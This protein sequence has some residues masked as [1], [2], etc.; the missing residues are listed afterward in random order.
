MSQENPSVTNN[1]HDS[2]P[3]DTDDDTFDIPV[4]QETIESDPTEDNNESPNASEPDSIVTLSLGEALLDNNADSDLAAFEAMV[5]GRKPTLPEIN[6]TQVEATPANPAPIPP[7]YKTA[8]PAYAPPAQ[9]VVAKGENPFLPK[10]ILDRLNHGKRNLV[11]EIAQSGAALDASTA[12]LR[13]R[14]RA[15]SLQRHGF[16]DPNT[17]STAT[18]NR[19]KNT[20]KKQQLIDELVEEYLPLLASEL[21]RRLRKVLDE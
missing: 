18:S 2:T 14:A 13:N 12:L 19:D 20:Y 21:R 17:A 3:L 9:P 5:F 6:T 10:H 15:D 16:S 4:L 1:T 7:T 11:E 8:T